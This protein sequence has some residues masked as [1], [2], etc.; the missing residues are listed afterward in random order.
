MTFAYQ[1]FAVVA[2]PQAEVVRALARIAAPDEDGARPPNGFDA[3]TSNG[4]GA[5]TEP[6]S[7][8]RS[9][10]GALARLT[11]TKT[12]KSAARSAVREPE[13][14][15]RC[16]VEAAPER[17]ITWRD[18]EETPARRVSAIAMRPTWSLLEF[19]DP[20]RG[21]SQVAADLSEALGGRE[22][23]FF[24]R[25]GAEAQAP[26][27]DYH[28]Y[29]G[30][31][32]ERRVFSHCTFPKRGEPWW[33]AAA[34]GPLTPYEDAGLYDGAE[35]A[36]LVTDRTLGAILAAMGLDMA[37]LFSLK[38][39]QSPILF[40]DRPGGAPLSQMAGVLLR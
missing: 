30:A 18:G 1:D 7:S 17:L 13:T 27:F 36:D 35:Q 4:D 11:S 37:E 32:P 26:L 31:S 23:F 25:S 20:S 12:L 34:E 16:D 33:E 28:L 21:L 40:D 15:L 6:G 19:A 5:D 22:V 29:R 14:Y 2:A 38:A 8:S 10:F 39:R 24:R 3:P 9:V